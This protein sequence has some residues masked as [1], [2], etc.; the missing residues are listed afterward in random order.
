MTNLYNWT[1][2]KGENITQQQLE[3]EWG[4]RY[5]DDPDRF[6][7]DLL[8]TKAQVEAILRSQ[9]NPATVTTRQKGLQ[10]LGSVDSADYN[11][12]RGR[13]A[14]ALMIRSFHE[15]QTTVDENELNADQRHA[16]DRALQ[17]EG[18]YVAAIKTVRRK[19]RSDGVLADTT[20]P[21]KRVE[22]RRRSM[23]D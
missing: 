20:A 8:R 15:L 13:N 2:R 6:K 11:V 19:L 1:L 23:F 9:K 3:A 17:V 14:R 18:D 16:Y 7:L 22:I 10:I 5:D 21:S 12:K 4:Y